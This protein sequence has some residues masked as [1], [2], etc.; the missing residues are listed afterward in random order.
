MSRIF[1]GV[2]CERNRAL[3]CHAVRTRHSCP[4]LSSQ[5]TRAQSYHGLC[6]D[7][8]V[9]G[10]VRCA[11]VRTRAMGGCGDACDGRVWG[12]VRSAHASALPILS[13]AV[14]Q[15]LCLSCHG[16]LCPGATVAYLPWL[17]CAYLSVT[18]LATSTG[19][20]LVSIT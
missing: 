13:W 15:A 8:R 12:R 3:S 4:V 17:G 2:S 10:R 14:T 9:C 20:T 6:C 1:G 16:P 18:T 11:G 5:V 19:P 7:G